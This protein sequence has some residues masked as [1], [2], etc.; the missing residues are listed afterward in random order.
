MK[1]T[2][3]VKSEQSMLVLL[4]IKLYVPIIFPVISEILISA[5]LKLNKIEI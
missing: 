2:P 4:F 5:F 1:Y 3:L